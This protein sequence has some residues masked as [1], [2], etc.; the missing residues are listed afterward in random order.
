MRR[1]VARIAVLTFA[2]A[3]GG[4]SVWND[5][6]GN[7]EEASIKLE[8]KA[9]KRI[10]AEI[11]LEKLWDRN[12]GKDTDGREARLVPALVGSRVFAVSV[13]GNA[14]ALDAADGRE[15]WRVN[16][17]EQTGGRWFRFRSV[18]HV[19]SGGVGAGADLIFVGLTDGS[20][21]ALSQNDGSLS[22]QVQMT[23]EVLAPPQV[24]GDKVIVQT[25]DGSIAALDVLDGEQQWSYTTSVP[26]LTLR[27]TTTP[28]VRSGFVVSGFANGRIAVLDLQNGIPRLDTK[29]AVAKGKSD[30]E[31]LVDVDGQ[32]VVDGSTLIAASYQGN[33]AAYDLQEGVPRWIKEL[34]ST[35]GLASGFGNVY[36][37]EDNG[38]VKA[39]DTQNANEVWSSDALEYREVSTPFT[40]GSFVL[41]GDFEGYLHVLAQS[42]GRF[43]GRRRVDRK[44]IQ[45]TAAV[46]GSRLYIIGNSGR[47]NAFEIR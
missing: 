10:D 36:A 34:S 38:H 16:V 6:F 24:G 44:G 26:A 30:L 4:C 17:G 35:A 32:L 33:I 1:I 14:Y 2:L 23:S 8:P 25:I 27:G 28:L 42:D 18:N 15:I 12:L 43:V 45:A 9:L 20:V 46:D 41:M 5:F 21:V 47:L 37:V 7:E 13:D 19:V 39:F 11:E 29:I 31:R 3:F 40:S 22:W